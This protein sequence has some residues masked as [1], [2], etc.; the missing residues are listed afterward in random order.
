VEIKGVNNS[1]GWLYGG[2]ADY[3]SFET[4]DYWLVVN[5]EKLKQFIS[6][7]CKDKIKALNTKDALYKLY[8]RDGRN[9]VITRVKTIDL[10]YIADKMLKK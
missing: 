4:I 1:K 9:D 5:R 10:I 7:K 2:K 6:E 8:T 3:I